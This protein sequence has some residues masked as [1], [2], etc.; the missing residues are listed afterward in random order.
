MGRDGAKRRPLTNRPDLSPERSR[1]YCPEVTCKAACL[2]HRI[3]WRPWLQAAVP[4]QEQGERYSDWS[5]ALWALVA[6]PVA[7]VGGENWA[8]RAVSRFG[9]AAPEAMRQSTGLD[10]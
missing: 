2:E 1:T 7:A 3:S 4:Y 8:Y 10:L 5:A 6:A 9:K